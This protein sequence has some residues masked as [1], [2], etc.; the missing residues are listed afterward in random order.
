MA[1]SNDISTSSKG[2]KCI[3][4]DETPSSGDKVIEISTTGDKVI[5]A[6]QNSSGDASNTSSPSA[7]KSIYCPNCGKKYY[8][9][10]SNYCTQC[11]QKRK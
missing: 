9:P 11:G 10:Y 6:S 5:D 3:E 1:N 8:M 2:A 7:F 4:V